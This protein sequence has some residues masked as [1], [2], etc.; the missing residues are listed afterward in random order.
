[1]RIN[2]ISYNVIL[3]GILFLNACE[4][5]EIKE[6]KSNQAEETAKPIAR[7]HEHFLYPSDLEGLVD[8]SISSEDSTSRVERY[9]NSWIRNQLLIDEA[10][11]K[12]DFDEAEIERKILEYRYSLM[13]YEYKSFHINKYLDKEVD[14]DEILKY[15]EKNL[16]NFP[17]RQNVIRGRI[18]KLPKAAPKVSQ[19]RRWIRSSREQDLID[20]RQYCLTY[21]T[22]YSLEDS[23]WINF[24]EL[25]KNTPVAEVTD[26][27]E[28]L[29]RNKYSELTDKESLY[30]LNVIEYKVSD[31]IAP[32]EIVYDQIKNIIINKRKVELAKKLQEDVYDRAK[33]NNEFEVYNN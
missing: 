22:L 1:M 26:K 23:L 24:D 17:L 9:V 27:A 12:M 19:V 8:S 31:D 3:V 28:F 4:L 33:Q 7:V 15:Y 20:L 14:D 32:V 5:L 30:F 21:S 16:D 10:S 18:V 2:L 29:K 6:D 11:T 25:V 13:G